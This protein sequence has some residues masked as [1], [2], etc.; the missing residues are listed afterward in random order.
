MIRNFLVCIFSLSS[1]FCQSQ[2]MP[3]FSFT[4][5]EKVGILG[6]KLDSIKKET[7]KYVDN[8]EIP[9]IQ[10]V[11]MRQGKIV[12][13]DSYGY[14]D[15]KSKRFLK[16]DDIF[17][18][19]SMTKS[20]TSIGLMMLYDKGLFDLYDPVDK[21]IPNFKN[22]MVYD[23]LGSKPLN[24]KVLII[25][26]LRHTSGIGYG[27]GTNKDIDKYYPKLWQ[28]KNNESFTNSLLKIPL[29]T[30]PGQEWRYGL[31]TDVC[32]Y[33]IEILA[34]QSLRIYFKNN[35]FEPLG[36]LDTHFELPDN[37]KERFVSNYI[38]D[39]TMFGKHLKRIDYYEDSSFLSVDR[40]SGGS[41]L[42]STSYDFLIFC[43]MLLNQGEFDG[44]RFIEEST[45]SMMTSNQ[46]PNL[47]Y[48]WGA[49]IK[50]GLG[51]S[52]VNNQELTKFHSVNGTFGWSG[53]SGT[54]FSIDPKNELITLIM[55]QRMYPWPENLFEK[56]N[57][58]VYESIVE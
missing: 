38:Y 55:T 25:D 4:D 44:K 7:H 21:Y 3:S 17:R 22:L 29:Y 20:V 13:Y 47:I 46:I 43:S 23:S 58:L 48:P 57:N 6:S 40:F 30:N 42:I 49:G 41:G 51:F 9:C 8:S 2:S 15:I 33:L 53:V 34:G 36:M 50:F 26:L 16:D 56:F 28:S 1:L 10:T 52:V 12:H 32:G 37:K 5:P 31:S 45:L 24:K 14:A 54:V 11:I 18:I 35:I 27:W 19:Y 39:K